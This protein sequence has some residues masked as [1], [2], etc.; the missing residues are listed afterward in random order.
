MVFAKDMTFDDEPI[1]LNI[2][3][4]APLYRDERGTVR[5]ADSNVLLDIVVGTFNQGCSAEEISRQYPT[6]SVAAV[7]GVLAYY[8]EYKSE[9]DG[10]LKIRRERADKI[11][12][13]VESQPEYIEWKKRFM[14]RAREKGLVK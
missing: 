14:E 3:E 9:V 11:R 13:H 2:P 1:P 5:V 10:Y 8:Q 6:A 12:A 4:D 7:K